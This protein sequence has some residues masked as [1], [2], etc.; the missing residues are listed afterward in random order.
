MRY[1]ITGEAPDLETID[2]VLTALDR[3]AG[4]GTWTCDIPAVDQ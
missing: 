2:R 4:P 1:V 3:V